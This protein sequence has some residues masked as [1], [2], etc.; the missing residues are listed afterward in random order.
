MYVN[1]GISFGAICLEYNIYI[2]F[3]ILHICDIQA[4]LVFEIHGVMVILEQIRE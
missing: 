2:L 1:L 3:K 4:I